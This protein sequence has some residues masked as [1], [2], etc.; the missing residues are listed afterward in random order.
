MVNELMDYK[1]HIEDAAS[2]KSD[3]DCDNSIIG[4]FEWVY[5]KTIIWQPKVIVCGKGRF[6]FSYWGWES[7][8]I[9]S[10]RNGLVWGWSCFENDSRQ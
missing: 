8:D 4:A 1:E 6:K 9:I 7:K 3:N 5:F 10:A 2:W